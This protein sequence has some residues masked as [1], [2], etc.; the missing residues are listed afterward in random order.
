MFFHMA[1]LNI[2]PAVR[3]NRENIL[4]QPWQKM[5]SPGNVVGIISSV[6]FLGSFPFRSIPPKNEN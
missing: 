4:S 1:S 5:L 2:V 6:L 3:L